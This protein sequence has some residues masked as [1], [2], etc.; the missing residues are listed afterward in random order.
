MLVAC[1]VEV[2]FAFFCFHERLEMKLAQFVLLEKRLEFEAKSEG[3][4]V[5]ILFSASIYTPTAHPFRDSAS[6][7]LDS[8][9]V[10]YYLQYPT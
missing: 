10:P 4:T 8:L 9:S 2:H 7:S 1:N 5:S 3:A 6:D